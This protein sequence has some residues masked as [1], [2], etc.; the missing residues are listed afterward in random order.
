MIR[1][2]QPTPTPL[3]LTLEYT[4][5][6]QTQ[7]LN[8]SE[9]PDYFLDFTP[10]PDE[11]LLTIGQSTAKL[12]RRG[13]YPIIQRQAP[14]GASAERAIASYE[15]S[16]KPSENSP[17]IKISKSLSPDESGAIPG[18]FE[19]ADDELSV[20]DHPITANIRSWPNSA[21]EAPEGWTPLVK[22]GQK[23]LVALRENQ[24]IRQ[25][26]IAMD[27]TLWDA[28]PDFVIFW[29]NLLDYLAGQ[30]GQYLFQPAVEKPQPLQKNNEIQL[31]PWFWASACVLAL[32]SS[33][34]FHKKDS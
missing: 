19:S 12:K 25:I 17:I 2:S 5:S 8:P 15:A 22:R 10:L 20:T 30:S 27:F 34:L 1:L 9:M 14:L 32:I 4:H 18:K 13:A 11:L 31:A 33:L 21:G 28:T 26:W 3:Q 16:R 23:S 6:R 7:T 29:T 24:S